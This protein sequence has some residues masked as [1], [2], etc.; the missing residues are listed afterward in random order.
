MSNEIPTR[1]I[2][3][4]LDE[5]SGKIPKLITSLMDTLYSADSGKR[6]GQSV[7]GFYKELVDSGIP[8][9]EALKMARDY[10]LSLKDIT[11]AFSN[12]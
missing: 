6:M 3:E 8:P 10:M 12:K 7:G 11:S 9:E 5:I 1:E 4:L 2:G